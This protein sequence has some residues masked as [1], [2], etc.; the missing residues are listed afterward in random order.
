MDFIIPKIVIFKGEI[1]AKGISTAS[2]TLEDGTS[3]DF[4]SVVIMPS[5]SASTDDGKAVSAGEYVEV[6]GSLE[7][8]EDVAEG[9]TVRVKCRVHVAGKTG[10]IDNATA[11]IHSSSALQIVEITP[12]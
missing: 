7:Q 3:K 2:K 12:I 10:Y 8:V 5:T 6:L 9:M 4:A 11:H 1:D